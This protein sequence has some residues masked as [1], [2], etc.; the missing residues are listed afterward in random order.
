MN[1]IQNVCCFT[2]HRPKYFHFGTSEQHPDCLKIK[3]FI[4]HNCERLIRDEGVTH[5]ISGGAVGVDTWA[6]EEI[7]E[8]RKLYPH[9]TLECV[10]PY[11]TMVKQFTPKNQDRYALI[12]PELQQITI[13]NECYHSGCMHQRNKHMVDRSQ[14]LIAVWTGQKSGTANTVNYAKKQGR[15]VFCLE[16]I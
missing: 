16:T 9:I 5:F 14:Y 11:A 13:L 2:G 8:L 12:K 1:T 4:R 3:N 15:T 7:I 10:L 6:M